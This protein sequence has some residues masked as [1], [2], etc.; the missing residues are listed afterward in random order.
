MR[1]LD[2]YLKLHEFTSPSVVIENVPESFLD[3][4]RGS[5]SMRFFNGNEA[6]DKFGSLFIDLEDAITSIG[7]RGF[8]KLDL[9]AP[10][11]A[12]WISVGKNLLCYDANDVAMLLKASNT[13]RNHLE[14]SVNKTHQIVIRSWIDFHPSGE[15]RCFVKNSKLIAITQK[16]IDIYFPFL[17]E[18]KK[19]RNLLS[20]F[21]ERHILNTL[22]GTF[23]IDLYFDFSGGGNIS[24]IDVT[25]WTESGSKP[26]FYLFDEQ[27][28]L[29]HYNCLLKSQNCLCLFRIVPKE[30]ERINPSYHARSDCWPD[31]LSFCDGDP[32]MLMKCFVLE[33]AQVSNSQSSSEEQEEIDH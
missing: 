11:D 20:T 2:W 28:L 18:E 5:S 22:D 21:V 7:G 26:D 1:F 16:Q 6:D 9:K 23:A 14:N 29:D 24:V 3:Y 31:D 33:A 25:P 19:L 4:L 27:T 30:F 10:L 32:S 8:V 17:E 12:K 15:F 13:I